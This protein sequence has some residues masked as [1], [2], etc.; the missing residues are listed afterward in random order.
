MEICGKNDLGQTVQ[1]W[2]P[3]LLSFLASPDETLSQETLDYLF[4]HSADPV[5]AKIVHFR[6]RNL[7]GL[8][9]TQ[10]KKL[11]EDLIQEV[12]LKILVQL[13]FLQANPAAEPIRDF[14]SYVARITHNLLHDYFRD[15]FRSPIVSDGKSAIYQHEDNEQQPADSDDFIKSLPDFV[16]NLEEKDERVFRLK[17]IWGEICQLPTNQATA[18]LLKVSDKQGQSTLK[19]L[20]VYQIATIRQIAEAMSQPPETLAAVWNELP[21]PDKKIAD[22]L[23]L[24]QRQV[25]NLR[26]SA[27]ARLQ[28]RLQ[29]LI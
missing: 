21:L 28:R 25:I 18:W 8:S 27:N 6:T 1:N 26:K 17:I 7:Y 9:Y 12:R 10:R 13:R 11:C 2:D 22:L 24:N 4:T 19:W 3:Q 20:P 5:C 14:Q 15:S 23:K 29:K 16:V